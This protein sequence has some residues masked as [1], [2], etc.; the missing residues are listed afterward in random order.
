MNISRHAFVSRTL[1]V[2]HLCNNKLLSGLMLMGIPYEPTHP[3]L[4]PLVKAG[5]LK[6]SAQGSADC[7]AL[8]YLKKKK[9]EK[10]RRRIERPQVV[11]FIID[12]Y[13]VPRLLSSELFIK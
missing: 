5:K 13:R 10:R 4:H 1:I 2:N 7:Q 12:V 8:L 11:L 3:F 9:K 6:L